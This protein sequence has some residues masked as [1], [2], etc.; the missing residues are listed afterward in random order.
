MGKYTFSNR[1]A[2]S[3]AVKKDTHPVWQGVGCLLIV[4]VP[5]MSIAAAIFTVQMSIALK[6]PLPYQLFLPM[7]LPAILFSTP[8]LVMIFTPLTKIDYPFAY[9]AFTL[10]Y[11]IVLGGI[12]SL[13]YAITYNLVGPP[14]YGPMDVERP[15][16]YRVK[17]YKR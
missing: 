11:M 13:I 12:I 1:Q 8:A 4:I 14:R 6:W 15:R 16:G 10:L 17:R 5:A 3:A 2:P 9:I 7:Q